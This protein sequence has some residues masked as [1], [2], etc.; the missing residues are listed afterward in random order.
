MKFRIGDRVKCVKLDT[1]PGCNRKYVKVGKAYTVS[2]PSQMTETQFTLEEV[3]AK[4]PDCPLFEQDDFEIYVEPSHV[5]DY[6][7]AMRGI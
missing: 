1:T 5:D 7:R 2:I 4:H 6:E 3:N